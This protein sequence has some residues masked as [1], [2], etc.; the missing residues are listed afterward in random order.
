AEGEHKIE[1]VERDPAGNSSEKSDPVMVIVDTTAPDAPRISGVIDNVGD[2]TGP[3]NPGDVTDDANPTVR[4]VAEP[5]ALVT[6]YDGE[7]VVGSTYADADGNWEIVTDTLL[8]GP[9]SLTVKATDAAGNVSD[10]SDPFDFSLI[11]GG[12][13]AAPSIVNV[14]DNAGDLTGNISPEGVTD[15]PRPTIVGTAQPG[16]V[17]RIYDVVDGHEVELGSTVADES[18]RW[19][20]RPDEA[21]ALS[22][23]EHNLK[24]TAEDAAGNMSPPTG[25]Y[26]IEVDTTPPA[27]LEELTL[28]DDVGDV[29]GPINSGDTSDDDR[30]TFSGRGEPGATIIIRDGDEVIGSTRVEEDGRW[31]WEPTE[32]LNDGPHSL[33]AQPVDRAGNKGPISE[34]IDF[35]VDTRDVVISITSV[36]DNA[37]S[38]TG[39]IDP[40]GVTDDTTPT[41]HGRATPGGVV[42]IYDGETLLGSAVADEDGNWTFEVPAAMALSEGVHTL[43]ATVTV[44]GQ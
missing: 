39:P 18:G 43:N 22:D 38:V 3:L 10:P 36:M 19:E 2:Q 16:M 26:P 14:I 25:L 12:N 24:A 9:H 28:I 5:H 35:V 32:P 13:P 27:A 29:T 20:F 6:L 17:V 34:P 7:R 44:P 37:G 15:D 31:S 8:N 30:P 4:G 11:T 42:R 41:V 33:T 40:N 1:V 23:G 21:H